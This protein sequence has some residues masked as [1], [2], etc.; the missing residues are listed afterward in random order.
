[1]RAA[2][3]DCSR[4]GVSISVVRPQPRPV[5]QPLRFAATCG[6][7]STTGPEGEG[8]VLH[9][10]LWPPCLLLGLFRP[11]TTNKTTKVLFIGE[12]T[13]QAEGGFHGGG[14]FN[15]SPSGSMEPVA[16]ILMIPPREPV[17]SI[18]DDLPGGTMNP[19]EL[20]TT[21]AFSANSR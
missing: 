12:A 15:C 10:K 8:N 5:L 20:W 21:D 6:T 2:F 11:P 3:I 18:E 9:K 4:L 7:S 14:A 1:M 13:G 19:E 17:L 16:M